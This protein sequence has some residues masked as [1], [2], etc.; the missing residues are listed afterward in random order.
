MVMSSRKMSIA[1]QN[2]TGI[3]K[4]VYDAVP[5]AEAWDTHR[6]VAWLKHQGMNPNLQ[7]IEGCLGSL[8]RDGLVRERPRG[9]WQRIEPR[10]DQAQDAPT[11]P[12]PE[13]P[14]RPVLTLASAAP[15]LPP[16][17]VDPFARF[18]ELSAALRERAAQLTAMAD[19]IDDTAIA[20]QQRVDAADGDGEKLRRLQATL[21]DLMG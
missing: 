10:A 2:L 11:D 16:A 21:K 1:E 7:I 14:A 3:A 8:V 17:P 6:I 13:K 18:G 19:E 4:R 15:A 5:I 9:T 12:L 20:M